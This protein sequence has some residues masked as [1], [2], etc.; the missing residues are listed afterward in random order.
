MK[1]WSIKQKANQEGFKK[2]QANAIATPGFWGAF[3]II[4]LNN[5]KRSDRKDSRRK[6]GSEPNTC[7]LL[8]VQIPRTFRP[9]ECR[10]HNP[11]FVVSH[12]GSLEVESR[13]LKEAI[14]SITEAL[15]LVIHGVPLAKLGS[16]SSSCVN[17]STF[18]QTAPACKDS[19]PV[20]PYSDSA[21]LRPFAIHTF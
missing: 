9:S 1:F 5:I 21:L 11:T 19:A 3:S 4:S 20:M 12:P 13:W 16:T 2:A 10:M 8:R 15:N 18:K 7:R 17:G 14:Q 6:N